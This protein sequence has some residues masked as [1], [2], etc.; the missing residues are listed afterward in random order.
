M[1]T[2]RQ[3]NKMKKAFKNGYSEDVQALLNERGI[4]SKKG[5]AFSISYITHVFNG[6][7]SNDFIENAIFD[8]YQKRIY[9]ESKMKQNREKI[10]SNSAQ[11]F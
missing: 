9:N 5:S 8:I 6:R 4:V 1:I 11:N 10:L 3:K 2:P 7:N